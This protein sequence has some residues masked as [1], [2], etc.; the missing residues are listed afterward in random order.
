MG[1][2]IVVILSQS[3]SLLALTAST[4]QAQSVSHTTFGMVASTPCIST[5]EDAGVVDILSKAS[6]WVGT[7]SASVP[8]SATGYPTASPGDDGFNSLF[9][10]AG[11]TPG[12]LKCNFYGEG[13]YKIA[14]YGNYVQGIVPGTMEQ[15]VDSRGITI[16]RF[17]VEF[18]VPQPTL[19]GWGAAGTNI[20]LS[21]FTL[22]Q[23]N[24]EQVPNGTPNNFHLTLPGY[25][26]WQN[27]GNNPLFTKEYLQAG[28]PFSSM[29][30]YLGANNS[31]N[32]TRTIDWS[33]RPQPGYYGAGDNPLGMP[34]ELMIAYC[35]QLDCDLWICVPL[36][37]TTNWKKQFATLVKNTLK[38]GHYCYIEHCNEMWNWGYFDS[39]YWVD[40]QAKADGFEQYAPWF[41]HGMEMG[42]LLMSDVV[43]MSPIMGAMLRPVLA[44]AFVTTD[45]AQ[46]G[47]KY[48]S[49][50]FGPPSQYIYA[51]AGAPYFLL[52]S[53][54]PTPTNLDQ[55]FQSIQDNLNSWLAPLLKQQMQ[56]ANGYGVKYCCYEC[57]QGLISTPESIFNLTFAAQTDPRMATMY[58]ILAGLLKSN[59]VAHVNLFA[60]SGLWSQWGFWGDLPQGS[61]ISHPPLRYLIDAGLANANNGRVPIKPVRTSSVGATSGHNTWA[62]QEAAKNAAKAAAKRRSC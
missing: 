33:D 32:A 54:D 45:Y 37:A 6:P 46:G 60:A 5:A 23:I 9:T 10:V 7:T 38:K 53:A 19:G 41:G 24:P 49:D 28:K 40:Q 3:A 1:L 14:L 26:A 51:I 2:L 20:P 4:C 34:Y 15:K 47:L 21:W 55:V 42:K 31:A 48:I 12:T 13:I 27:G 16:T 35:N 59:G 18:N 11:Y 29:R 56:L 57:G 17:V 61:M 22:S 50:Y 52:S 25:P 30:F 58:N 44:G 39:W 43:V 8:F 62:Q 36:Q